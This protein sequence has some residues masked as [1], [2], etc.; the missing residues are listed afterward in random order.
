MYVFICRTLDVVDVADVD[1]PHVVVATTE[2]F[3]KD[4]VDDVQADEVL[5][6]V[7]LGA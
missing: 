7:E 1:E 4:V 3:N 5:V 6:S 2:A